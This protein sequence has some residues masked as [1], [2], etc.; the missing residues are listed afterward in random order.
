MTELD[1]FAENIIKNG[2]IIESY[3]AIDSKENSVYAFEVN[4]ENNILLVVFN[5]QNHCTGIICK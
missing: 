5:N 4:F 2:R 3:T 1:R